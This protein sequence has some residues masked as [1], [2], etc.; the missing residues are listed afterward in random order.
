M[1][2][3]ENPMVL[4]APYAEASLYS[5]DWAQ[6][7]PS[8][9]ISLLAA[10]FLILLGMP[11]GFGMA[12]AGFL[13]VILY[14][15]RRPMVRLTAG[16]GARLGALTGALGF[17]VFAVTLALL[18]AFRSGSEIHDALVKYFQQYAAQSADP[19]MQ[20]VLDLI[21]TSDG[22]IVILVLSLA[23]TFIAFVVFASLGGA[24]G[25]FLLHRR[26]RAG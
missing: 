19:R 7:L 2:A 13:C 10:I 21:K 3:P 11:A 1:A 16:K 8:A 15:R 5:F 14:H 12:G 4:P 25:A 6:A 9:G 24:I 22:Y 20:Q 17:S 26:E 18:T 23:V